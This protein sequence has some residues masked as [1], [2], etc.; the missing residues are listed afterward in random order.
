MKPFNLFLL[1]FLLIQAYSCTKES[2]M[3]ELTAD[4]FSKNEKVTLSQ[5]DAERK[6]SEILSKATFKEPALR[7]FLKNQALQKK[8][9]DYNVFYPLTK[10]E[11]VTEDKTFFE[12]LRQ[13]TND[14][15]SL[16][17]IERAA[18]LLN[19]FIPDLTLFDRSLSVDK[20]DVKDGDIP[21]FNRGRFYWN[22][23]VIDSISEENAHALPIFH[24][25]VVN[26]SRRR[27]IKRGTTRSSGV[28]IEYDFADEA[29]NPKHTKI[30]TRFSGVTTYEKES[31]SELLDPNK[32]YVPTSEFPTATLN[33]FNKIGA[34][35]G[36]LRPM[37]Y[38]NLNKIEDLN[39]DNASIDY[40]V[41]DVIYRM[42][43][44]PYI[45]SY[46]SK[47]KEGSFQSPFVYDH[48]YYYKGNKN[49]P[50]FEEIVKHLWSEGNFVFKINVVTGDYAQLIT[51][52]I[53]PQDLFS[54][55]LKKWFKHKTWFSRREYKWWIVSSDL[56]SKWI[57]PHKMG[58]DA[59][60]SPWNPKTESYK[61]TIFVSSAGSNTT[62][63]KEVQVSNTVLK[64]KG[65]S[66]STGSKASFP[67]GVGATGE[68]NINLTY[69]WENQ[70]TDSYTSKVSIE[71]T[72]NDISLGNN[73][74]NFFGS[75]PILKVNNNKVYLDTQRYGC[76]DMCII[77]VNKNLQ[78]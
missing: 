11:I 71:V 25:F 21:I 34:G 22:G 65:G 39:S 77:P 35:N 55:T 33:V 44:D 49:E 3:P 66:V 74:F 2:L 73:S 38:Y 78:H 31:L 68:A 14:E 10:N 64:E 7:A 6:F 59:R 28:A 51:I 36:V 26:E 72:D 37:M 60:L 16:S 63:K 24:T 42:K 19:I 18:P 8:D 17:D 61:R 46:I 4:N 45:Y 48:F 47:I 57:Y 52:A 53:P 70:N 30:Q 43:I 5:Q 40:N 76:F 67:I 56:G 15:E 13:Y 23:V 69:S 29:Y 41:S 75:S 54:V 12:V 20:L 50:S 27:I 1:S 9:N 32:N 58:I 62:L